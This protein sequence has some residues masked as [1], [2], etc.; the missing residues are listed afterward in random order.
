[1]SREDNMTYKDIW[2]PFDWIT[3]QFRPMEPTFYFTDH[4]YKLYRFR[5]RYDY[6]T[7]D[8]SFAVACG[9]LEWVLSLVRD[10][11]NIN[12]DP[13]KKIKVEEALKECKEYFSEIRTWGI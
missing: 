12:D 10:N 5:F 8:M 2:R 6:L 4:G 9:G 13:E 1:M 7:H 11:Y 3:D